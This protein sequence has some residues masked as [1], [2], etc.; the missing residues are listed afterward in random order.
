MSVY[1]F[2]LALG[3]FLG[4]FIVLFVIVTA[5]WVW[6]IVWTMKKKELGEEATLEQAARYEGIRD[7]RMR[8]LK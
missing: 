7:D 5:G 6:M 1:S 8:L 4:L 2:E 3:L